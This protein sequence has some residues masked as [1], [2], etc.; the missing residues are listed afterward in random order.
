MNGTYRAMGRLYESPDEVLE[1]DAGYDLYPLALPANA[2]TAF[3]DGWYDAEERHA[4][5]A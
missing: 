1:H 4:P 5:W 3:S 2:T